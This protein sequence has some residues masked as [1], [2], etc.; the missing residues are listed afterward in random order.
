MNN[1]G[2]KKVIIT[3][4]GASGSGKDTLVDALL[5]LN[6]SGPANAPTSMAHIFSNLV[7]RDPLNLHKLISHT[8][9][10][11]RSGERN[12]IDYHFITEEQFGD[13][14]K[15]EESTYTGNHYC[16]A[17]SE[18]QGIDDFG[19]VVV[20]R[21]GVEHIRKFVSDHSDEYELYS[22]FLAITPK[23]SEARMISRGD[24]RESIAKRLHQQ[25]QNDEYSV[26]DSNY[27][28]FD[29]NTE[30]SLSANVLA[31]QRFLTGVHCVDNF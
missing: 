9:R 24:A 13:I 10:K 5:Y 29:A 17:V 3:V 22:F 27:I 16:L 25:E 1:T 12:A 7:S 23:T 14:N 4:T 6:S 8:T 2:T 19:I 11:P 18:L 30:D 21:N 28:W 15:I 26:P 31:V 20:D